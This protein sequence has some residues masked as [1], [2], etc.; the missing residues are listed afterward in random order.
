MS[1]FLSTVS[2]LVSVCWNS[3]ILLNF[4]EFYEI[5]LNFW[6]FYEIL[7][8]FWEFYE[9]CWICLYLPVSDCTV[10]CLTVL[11]RVCLYRLWPWLYRL[12]WLWWYQQCV[13]WWYQQWCTVVVSTVVKTRT[14]VTV[15]HQYPYTTTTPL[16]RVPH[17]CTHPVRMRHAPRWHTQWCSPGFFWLLRNLRKHAHFWPL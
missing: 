9:F 11:P 7:L 14:V 16:P 4:W 13:Q 10:P 8:N 12:W 15:I 6:K 3:E 5:L 2:V 1:V 17:H